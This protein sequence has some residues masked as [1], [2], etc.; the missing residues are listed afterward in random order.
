MPRKP[1]LRQDLLA[2]Y[3]ASNWMPDPDTLFE[4]IKKLEPGH[5]LT[6]TRDGTRK[7]RYWD[8]EFHP[9]EEVN[10]K[11]GNEQLSSVLQLSVE[12]QLRS[13]VPV[14]FFLSGGVDSSLLTAKA[15][16]VRHDRPNDFYHRVSL[17]QNSER[18]RV[19][20]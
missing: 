7:Y 19:R 5:Y 12:R 15:I 17:E 2:R 20:P 8:L 1:S 14:G 3:R 6:V 11:S 13:D 10:E 9:D 16:E 18:E 4:G